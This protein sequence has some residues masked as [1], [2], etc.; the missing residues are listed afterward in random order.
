MVISRC[1][2]LAACVLILASVTAALADAVRVLPEGQLPKDKRLGKLTDLNGYFPFTPAKNKQDWEKRAEQVRR[3]ILVANGLWP[4]PKPTPAKAVVHGK[5]DREG[6]SVERVF[7]ESYPGHFVTGNLYRPTG[8]SGKLPAVLCPH[9]HW[10]NGRFM[11]IGSEAAKKQI[12]E[13]AERFENGGRSVLQARCVQLARMGCIVFHYDMVGY[14]DSVQIPFALAHGF[15]K[16]RPE[17]DTSENWGFFSTQAELRAQSIMGLQTYNSIRALDW[18]ISLPEVDAARVGVTGASGGG[19]QTFILGAIDSRPAALFPAVMVSTGM[20][21]GC[22]CENC[23]NLRVGTGNIEFAAMAAPR[24][25]GMTGANDWTKELAT[26]GFPQLQEHYAMLGVPDRVSAKVMTQFGHNY[27]FVSREVMYHFFNKHLSLGL[28]EPIIE[29]DYKP[30]TTAELT[31]WDS[32][33]PRP[34]SGGDYERSLL[35]TM[36]E[37]SDRQMAEVDP[38]DAASLAR[39][40]ETVGAAFDVILARSLPPAD[41]VQLKSVGEESKGDYTLTKAVLRNVPNEEEIPLVIL[42]PQKWNKR[43]VL[44]LDEAG[45]SAL[46]DAQ[47][48][49]QALATGLLAAGSAVIAP[50][51]LYQGEFLADDKPLEQSPKVENPREFAGYTLG[52]NPALFAQRVDD[53]LTLVAFAKTYKGENPSIDVLGQGA[54]GAW[55]AAARAQAGT[56]ISRLAI[57]TRGFRFA[58]LRSTRDVNLLPGSVKYGDLPALLALGAPG[59]L[60]LAGEGEAEIPLVRGAY[61]AAGAENRLARTAGSSEA[62]REDAVKWLARSGNER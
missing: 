47:G 60:W 32:E 50:D 44:V 42:H 40:R 6:Y 20:Q 14:S 15:A 17:F 43:V 7:L 52:Y 10:P 8:K 34:A 3:R 16:Q 18:L 56:A 51:L 25:L 2:I 24:P 13:G 4:M 36:T 23:S 37:A 31:V 9:G 35:R 5:V 59:E 49:P 22:T 12:V 30:L 33:H 26:K 39:F 41:S 11:D 53:V 57:D 27:N 28:E 62:N 21:G 61:K 19:T 55:A 45:K 48:K 1:V 29:E 46:F 54:A 38:K 58:K